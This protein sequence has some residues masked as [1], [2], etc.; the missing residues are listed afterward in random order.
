MQSTSRVVIYYGLATNTLSHVL[1]SVYNKLFTASHATRRHRSH[2]A[3]IQALKH[4]ETSLGR[5]LDSFNHSRKHKHVLCTHRYNCAIYT[6]VGF[7]QR[8]LTGYALQAAFK[9]LGSIG[10]IIRKP[11]LLLKIL[12]SPVNKEF[13]LFLGSYTLIFR[14]V[15]CL[16]KR[17]TNKNSA[18]HGLVSGFFA[19]WSMLF[20]KSSSIALYL[21]FKLIEILYFIGVKNKTLPL[22]KWFDVVLYTISTAF[23]LWVVIILLNFIFILIFFKA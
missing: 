7:L 5:F 1:N 9:C 19:G 13:G 18:L 2:N 17:L 4:I 21:N 23:M 22:F 20:Y 10:G 6:L 14:A 15:S 8:F 16:L 12:L 3:F 11:R